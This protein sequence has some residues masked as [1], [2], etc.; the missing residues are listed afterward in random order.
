MSIRIIIVESG[1][2]Q[3]FVAEV[4][5]PK[6]AVLDFIN[7]RLEDDFDQC[8]DCQDWFTELQNE[9]GEFLCRDC[10]GYALDG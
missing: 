9:N 6:D 4:F 1:K 10:A 5:A 2:K 8:P 7:G 3:E